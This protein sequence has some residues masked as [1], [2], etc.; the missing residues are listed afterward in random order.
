MGRRCEPVGPGGVPRGRWRSTPRSSRRGTSIA[1][2]TD[3]GIPADEVGEM[4]VAAIRENRFW[5]LPNGEV[6]FPVFDRELDDVK[7][8]R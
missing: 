8:G 6:F 1:A 7:A 5:L 2:Y 3:A 4:V